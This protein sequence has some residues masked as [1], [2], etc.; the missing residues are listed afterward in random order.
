[1]LC[2]FRRTHASA[3]GVSEF[4]VSSDSCHQRN[5][6]DNGKNSI[7]AITVS[8]IRLWEFYTK[9]SFS[10]VLPSSDSHLFVFFSFFMVSRFCF[11]RLLFAKNPCSF[12]GFYF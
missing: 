8:F 1:M 2:N 11:P 10:G 6:D 3:S 7:V 9:P 5:G 4:W 12:K